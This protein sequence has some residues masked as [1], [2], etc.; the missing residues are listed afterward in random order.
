MVNLV[1]I[2][3]SA[4]PLQEGASAVFVQVLDLDTT[5][6]GKALQTGITTAVDTT[7][8]TDILATVQ[9]A[10]PGY[11]VFDSPESMSVVI[12]DLLVEAGLRVRDP[13]TG[14]ISLSQEAIALDNGGLL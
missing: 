13:V 11:Q 3:G 9:A 14:V 4:P 10:Y 8:S 6:F 12:Q 7:N 5:L 2:L 1:A